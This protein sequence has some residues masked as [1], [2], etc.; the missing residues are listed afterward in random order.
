MEADIFT[1][2]TTCAVLIDTLGHEAPQTMW[3]LLDI[4]TKDAMWEEAVLTNFDGK[5]EAMAPQNRE[6]NDDEANMTNWC[7]D[8]MKK[9]DKK[10]L[11]EDMVAVDEGVPCGPK[12]RGR[13]SVLTTLRKRSRKCAYPTKARPS[14]SSRIVKPCEATSRACSTLII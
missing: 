11:W 6:D 12:R 13:A 3:E 10:C 4:M 5:N 8:K 2:G 14:T 1:Y 9:S 7:C